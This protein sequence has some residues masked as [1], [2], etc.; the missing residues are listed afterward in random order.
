MM[1]KK[2]KFKDRPLPKPD[3]K[4]AMQQEEKARKRKE[5]KQERADVREEKKKVTKPMEAQKKV[6]YKESEVSWEAINQLNFDQLR[7]KKFNPA[8]IL[9][10]TDDDR[11]FLEE[12]G[13]RPKITERMQVRER[14]SLSIVESTKSRAAELER[15][16]QGQTGGK[17]EKGGSGSRRL[18]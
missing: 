17:R 2:E 11:Y 1:E 18:F 7:L 5:A 14:Q 4:H 9:T 15:R 16:E 6:E 3:N 8:K 10:P 12:Y 13:G